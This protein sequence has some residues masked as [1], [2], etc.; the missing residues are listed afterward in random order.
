RTLV[1]VEDRPELSDVTM[2]SLLRRGGLL[3]AVSTGG[4][5]P[6]LAARLRRFLE[7]VLG[8]E[9]AERVER[10]AALR[11]ALRARGLAPPEVRRACEA[12]IE[13]EGWL[14]P[15]AGAPVREPAVERLRRAVAFAAA[16]ARG[17]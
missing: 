13:A 11:D 8:E 12:L 2:P 14:P 10:I 3:V 9:W 17:R 7:D 1:H 15:P 4:R 5:S 16:A 6:T